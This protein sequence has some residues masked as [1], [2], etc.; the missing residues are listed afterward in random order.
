MAEGKS[1]GELK[2]GDSAQ[3]SNPASWGI[4]FQDM[5]PSTFLKKSGFS[6]LR[7]SEIPSRLGWKSS[8]LSQ[9]KIGQNL[10]RPAQI[11]KA[12]WSWM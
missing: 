10:E 7:E 11:K 9:E 5:V 12:K 8:N 6:L 2:V 3:I 4:F 1:I